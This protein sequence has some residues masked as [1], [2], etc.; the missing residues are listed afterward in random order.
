MLITKRN[1]L[2]SK[3]AVAPS[4]PIFLHQILDMGHSLLQL[5]VLWWFL[6]LLVR[7][8]AQPLGRYGMDDS[9][10]YQSMNVYHDILYHECFLLLLIKY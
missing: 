5:L 3:H 7:W 9:I 6:F 10:I 1:L 8:F 2:T 4:V